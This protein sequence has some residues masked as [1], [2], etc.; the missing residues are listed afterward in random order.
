M[1][2]IYS[3]MI[4]DHD[5]RFVV[6]AASVCLLAALTAFT[7][8][9]H[10]RER[11]IT[12]RARWIVLAGVVNGGGIW[13]THFIAMLAYQPQ[14][15]TVY[16]VIPTLVSILIAALMAT[17]G[18]WLAISAR[19]WAATCGAIV[20]TAG[21]GMMHFTG[22]SALKTTGMLSYDPIIIG[23]ACAGAA[24]FA[25]IA[26]NWHQHWPR[27]LPVGPAVAL[28]LGICTLHFGSMAAVTIIP[29][30]TI[31]IP[32]ASVSREM[33]AVVITLLVVILLVAALATAVMDARISHFAQKIDHLTSHDALTGL[34]NTPEFQSALYAMLSK[35][36]RFEGST[37]LLCVGGDRFKVI[38]DV[39]G[40]PVGD[41]VLVD[42]ARRINTCCGNAF[43]ARLG[44]DE[45]AILT[46]D[47]DEGRHAARL[48][49]QIIDSL[50]VPV[51]IDDLN[52]RVGV[53]IGIATFPQ[54]AK[55]G[56]DLR[57]KA[58]LALCRAKSLGRGIACPYKPDM[59]EMVRDKHKLENALRN[60]LLN[61]QLSVHYQ[62]IVCAETGGALGFEALLR[63]CH[64][65]Y[66]EIS[67]AQ[68]VPIAEADGLIIKIGA[69]VLNE[70]CREAQSWRQPLKVAVNLSAVQFTDHGLVEK[71]R[72]ALAESGLD[73]SR[74]ELEITE[75]LLIDDTENALRVLH[76]LKSMGVRIAMDDFGTGFSS[77]SYFRQFPFDKVKI[78]QSFVRDMAENRQSM[79]VVKAVIGIGQALDILVLAEG[80]ETVEQLDILSAAGCHQL[81]GYLLGRPKM[82]AQ[83]ENL[84]MRRSSESHACGNECE[85][86]LERLRPPC[87]AKVA[88]IPAVR[89]T[90]FAARTKAA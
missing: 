36:K 20:I 19:H 16:S 39:Y 71:V 12:Q 87:G 51:R 61:N 8:A 46:Q 55:D 33:L 56:P 35:A 17:V 69:W 70:S 79:A 66:G 83:Y 9:G 28:T 40:Y 53:S 75:G 82:I 21:I 89:M 59:D 47:N 62:P 49:E 27:R 67:P 34:A 86:C 52:I 65:E 18:W 2:K 63:W 60:A 5:P 64:P 68:F 43:V 23:G 76:E 25:V 78:D 29:D 73:A 31:N 13:A 6:F 50:A 42:I 57:R 22:M 80:V 10:I 30:S 77:L 85:S 11:A 14:L 45:F 84:T 58:D 72:I 24:I 15:P 1:L 48:A 54:D 7:L 26:L 81:Q 37:S 38:N 74:L 41:R 3:C 88:K 44:G 4:A 90:S 32:V